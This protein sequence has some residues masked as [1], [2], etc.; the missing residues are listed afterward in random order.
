MPRICFKI[1]A[2]SLA[3][4]INVE[5]AETVTNLLTK[6]FSWTLDTYSQNVFFVTV[7]TSNL[8]Q[9]FFKF[10]ARSSVITGFSAKIIICIDFCS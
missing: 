8:T 10:F 1:I 4:V 7:V 6:R 2:S 9:I 5:V 3:S